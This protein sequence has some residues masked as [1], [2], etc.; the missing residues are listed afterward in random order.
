MWS[1]VLVWWLWISGEGLFKVVCPISIRV[2]VCLK[3]SR[4]YQFNLDTLGIH[5]CS[6]FSPLNLGKQPIRPRFISILFQPLDR[7][8]LTHRRLHAGNRIE[9]GHTGLGRLSFRNSPHK[10]RD[11]LERL[12]HNNRR[13]KESP[14]IV[15]LL[16]PNFK[17]DLFAETS[18]TQSEEDV[19]VEQGIVAACQ[20]QLR[21]QSS[22]SIN[23]RPEI[24]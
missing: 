19:F 2:F 20:N 8:L 15:R 16:L 10:F 22:F 1:V 13:A 14:G 5:L 11:A 21:R 7:I 17:L 9:A 6:L 24:R 3:Q 18:S 12:S 4:Q 23:E